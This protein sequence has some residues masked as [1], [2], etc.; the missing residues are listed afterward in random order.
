MCELLL[1]SDFDPA[2]KVRIAYHNHWNEP[3]DWDKHAARQ[4]NPVTIEG[5]ERHY[6]GQTGIIDQIHKGL[7]KKK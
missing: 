3:Y 1:S 2:N 6:I 4:S 7:W 5:R